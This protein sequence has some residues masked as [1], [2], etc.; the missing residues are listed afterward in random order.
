LTTR[1]T[2]PPDSGICEVSTHIAAGLTGPKNI[3]SGEPFRKGAD[4]R[5]KMTGATIAMIGR[6]LIMRTSYRFAS[7]ACSE[8][9]FSEYRDT[10]APWLN[11]DRLPF[12]IA[13][14]HN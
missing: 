1:V 14:W 4:G 12:L 3:G 2:F 10:D 7:T 9:L 13:S 8:E 11:G 6:W 5:H